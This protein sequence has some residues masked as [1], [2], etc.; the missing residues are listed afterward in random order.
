MGVPCLT[1][2]EN[3][4]RPVTIEMGT[5]I[6]AGT[7]KNTILQAYKKIGEKKGKNHRVPPKW[8]GRAAERIWRVILN[9]KRA[10]GMGSFL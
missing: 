6:L 10:E 9:V 3:T 2:R 1:L 5:N 7:K 8:D 4:E